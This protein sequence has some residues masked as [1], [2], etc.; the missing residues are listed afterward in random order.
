MI[1]LEYY[2]AYCADMQRV[3]D[4]IKLENEARERQ[5]RANVLL[6]A[7]LRKM[8]RAAFRLNRKHDNPRHHVAMTS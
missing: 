5:T 6:L 7:R 2:N 3:D 8:V 1:S 4:K